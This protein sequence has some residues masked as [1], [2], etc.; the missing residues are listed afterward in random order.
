MLMQ[1]T[2]I[3]TKVT[4]TNALM[5]SQKVVAILHIQTNSKQQDSSAPSFAGA[6]KY[7]LQS[8]FSQ[9]PFDKM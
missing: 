1:H 6:K 8:V 7:F 2:K 4:S 5:W 9:Y 3:S